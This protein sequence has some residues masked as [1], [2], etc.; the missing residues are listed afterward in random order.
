MFINFTKWGKVLTQFVSNFVCFRFLLLILTKFNTR[1]N[2]F[3]CVSMNVYDLN[4]VYLFGFELWKTRIVATV[5]EKRKNEIKSNKS[6]TNANKRGRKIK[7][8]EVA[9]VSEEALN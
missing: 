6:K 5:T 2:Q 8:I 3:G 4:S 1:C 9:S 7:Y